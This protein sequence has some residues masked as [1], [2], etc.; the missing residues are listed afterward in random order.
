MSLYRA[1][2]FEVDPIKQPAVAD[3][4][5]WDEDAAY[6]LVHATPETYWKK[7]MRTLSRDGFDGEHA[8]DIPFRPLPGSVSRRNLG[9]WMIGKLPDGQHL[10]LS[11]GKTQGAGDEIELL[12]SFGQKDGQ[13]ITFYPAS[14]RNI[15]AYLRSCKPG[16]TTRGLGAR[17]RLGIGV[18]ATVLAWPGIWQ[19]M[20]KKD[21]CANA[22]QNSLR[23]LNLL[24]DLRSGNEPRE[25]YQFSFGSVQEGHTGSTFEGLWLTGVL[26][27]LEYDATLDFGADADHIM[28]KRDD[29]SIFAD[30]AI[31]HPG[32][33]RA[34]QIILA[35]KHYSFYT[36]DVS[37]LLDYGILHDTSG[38]IGIERLAEIVGDQENIDT[39]VGY[40]NRTPGTISEEHLGRFVGKYWEAL[41]AI[42]ELSA[43]TKALKGEEL[44]DLELSIDENPPGIETCSNT[45]TTDELSFLI[46]EI[47]RRNIQVTH[48]APNFGIEKGTDFRCPEGLDGLG[49]RVKQLSEIAGEAG[50]MLDCHSG[51]DLSSETMAVIG[52]AASGNIHFKVSPSLQVLLGE[53]IHDVSPKLFEHWWELSLGYAR[54]KQEE[55]SELADQVLGSLESG[56]KT[57]PSPEHPLFHHFCFAP[58]GERDKQGRFI[59]RAWFYELPKSVE[60]EYTTRLCE[61]LCDL[62]ELIFR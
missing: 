19:A 54:R 5:T 62:S 59:N 13:N 35:A 51:D 1:G 6:E 2:A 50:I 39:L 14:D 48:I 18:R 25:N 26:S 43:Y 38:T 33:E 31:T 44:F 28:V 55:G 22:I 52:K 60:R 15:N 45:T 4:A 29:A 30:P 47:H 42:E 61:H 3:T 17:P 41:D 12:K 40:H 16:R 53:C 20:I 37:D 58:V 46:R 34:K 21:F 9:T 8:T 10:I 57:R 23:E 32:R 7:M 11:I 56:T 27:A 49:R 24:E 36:L